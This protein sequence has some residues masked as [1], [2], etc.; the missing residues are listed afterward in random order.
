MSAAGPSSQ[1]RQSER[2]AGYPVGDGYPGAF[3]TSQVHGQRRRPMSA[4]L[5]PLRR[6]FSLEKHGPVLLVLMLL[7]APAMAQDA[8]P[9]TPAETDQG[10]GST[11]HHGT[12]VPMHD[13]MIGDVNHYASRYP[14]AFVVEL[15]RYYDVRP[16]QITRWLHEGA[17]SPG[18]LLY[19]CALAQA[20]VRPCVEVIQ[21]WRQPQGVAWPEVRAALDIAPGSAQERRLDAR[22]RASYVRWARPLPEA[23]R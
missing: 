10:E 7:A 5:S 15:T 22:L 17:L 14:Q 20:A 1:A 21:Q 4:W 6:R 2:P 23:T 12:G 11:P 9:A 18:N 13:R 16:E 8:A 19:A 3:A